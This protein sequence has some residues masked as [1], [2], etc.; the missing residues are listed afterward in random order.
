MK[1][2][3]LPVNDYKDDIEYIEEPIEE[4]ETRDVFIVYKVL[5]WIGYFFLSI[6]LFLGIMFIAV[7]IGG[8]HQKLEMNPGFALLGVILCLPFVLYVVISNYMDKSPKIDNENQVTSVRKSSQLA[9]KVDLK[10]IKLVQNSFNYIDVIFIIPY[11][12]KNVVIHYKQKIEMEYDNILLWFIQQKETTFY[13][14]PEDINQHYID[15]EFMN[16]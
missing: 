16:N 2:I 1:I 14:N 4:S 6:I 8:K 3:K 15:L 13:I 11:P 7:G 9:L 12:Q 5:R 10:N